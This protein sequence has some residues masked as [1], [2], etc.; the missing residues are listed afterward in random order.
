MACKDTRRD[1]I[2]RVAVA[3]WPGGVYSLA[4]TPVLDNGFDFFYSSD[5]LYFFVLTLKIHR[6][7][8]SLILCWAVQSEEQCR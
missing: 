1:E 3:G 5:V 7:F 4:Y 8:V 6:S 2:T